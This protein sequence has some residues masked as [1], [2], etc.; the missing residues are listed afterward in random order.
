MILEIVTYPD[1]R[2][3]QKSKDVKFFD[4]QLHLFLDNMYETMLAKNG[5]GLAGIQVGLLL[6]ILIIN[7]PDENDEQNKNDLLEIINPKIINSVG[8][9]SNSEGCLSVP[10]IFEDVDR[11]DRII[12]EYYNRLGK[13]QTLEADGFLSI[14]LQH[15]ID[16]LNG[17]LFIDKLPLTKRKSFEKEYKKL[18]KK[19]R[20]ENKN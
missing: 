17:K 9:S 13:K 20:K 11:F 2:L 18:R 14:C 19:N 10:E 3:K 4:K 15:E 16:H 6:N 7:L 5:I 12:I 1:K 8:K